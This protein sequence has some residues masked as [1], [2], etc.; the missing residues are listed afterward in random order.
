MAHANDA[1]EKKGKMWRT[2]A[3]FT[4][5]D[6]EEEEENKKLA[7]DKDIIHKKIQLWTNK[8]ENE[9]AIRLLLDGDTRFESVGKEGYREFIASTDSAERY[10]HPIAET[11]KL[12]VLQNGWDYA[13]RDFVDNYKKDH[14]GI[15][16]SPASA[17]PS[18]NRMSSSS[19]SIS[20]TTTRDKGD[21]N[22]EHTDK[23]YPIKFI[24]LHR[25]T[26]CDEE[27]RN[28]EE[29]KEHELRWHV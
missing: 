1:D 16:R 4:I 23:D 9:Y 10:T 6:D 26:Y 11:D 21:D 7:S 13:L 22:K 8:E 5:N 17:F 19:S 14:R 3:N 12:D 20:G 27:F 24:S 15:S 29:R 2:K 28:E 25:C 18:Y